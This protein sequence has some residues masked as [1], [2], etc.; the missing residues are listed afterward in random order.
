M[1][2]TSKSVTITPPAKRPSTAKK[3]QGAGS[4]VTAPAELKAFHHDGGLDPNFG[5]ARFWWEGDGPREGIA[6]KV[7]QK[8]H[9]VAD[10]DDPAAVTAARTDLLLPV[11]A[12]AD[13]ADVRHLL[14]RFDAKLPTSEKHAF[15]QITL[16]F[17]GATNIH[18]PFEEARAFADE[19]LVAE[20][21]LATI[22]VAHAPFL[23]GS[24]NALH[25]HLLCPLRRLGA[26]G[27]GE[28][29]PWLQNDRGRVE[30]FEAWTAHP[31]RWREGGCDLG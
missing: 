31:E 6:G 22:I 8:F 21:R 3:A 28:M 23:A 16:R 29:E 13:Y 26:L 24:A 17:P 7:L 18:G 11:D 14:E 1:A 12:Q 4:L 27:W 9:P 2:A 30:T 10:P 5:F 25:L 20:R 15:V 19:F